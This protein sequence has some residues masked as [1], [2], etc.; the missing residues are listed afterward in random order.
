MTRFPIFL[1]VVYVL[2]NEAEQVASLLLAATQQ[3]EN[4]VDDYELIVVDNASEDMTLSVL[5]ALTGIDG[6]PNLQ[7]FSLTQE[8]HFDVAAWVG[9]QNALG[10]HIAV[11]DPLTDD[12]SV[13]PQMLQSSV[14]G[15][16]IVFAANR[17][18]PAQ[19]LAYRAAHA[20]FAGL[21]RLLHGIDLSTEAPPFRLVNRR[22]VGYLLQHPQPAMTYRHLGA[23]GGFTRKRLDYSADPAGARQRRLSESIDRGMRLLLSTSRTPLRLVTGLALFGAFAN[24]AYSAYIVAIAFFKED[25]APG[26]VSL[27][28]QQSGMFFLLSVLLL[29]LGEYVLHLVRISNDGPSYFI[30]QE[31]TSTRMGRDRKLNVQTG[32]P[33]ATQVSRALD[34]RRESHGGRTG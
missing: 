22:V 13:L 31:L 23:T 34:P 12:L 20:V 3:L 24:L 15:V 28:L 30:G 17:R 18:R 9:L 6:L 25:V 19:S 32:A 26:W 10:N 14:D 7:I 1:S 8:V 27:S 21:Y 2:R 16:D 33:G 4:L 29:V 5:K 11:L